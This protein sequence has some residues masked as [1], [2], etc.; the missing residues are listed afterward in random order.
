[1]SSKKTIKSPQQSNERGFQIK[2]SNENL[3]AQNETLETSSYAKISMFEKKLIIEKD[4]SPYKKKANRI[5]IIASI[6]VL[7]LIVAIIALT[8]T[9]ISLFGKK[10]K[11]KQIFY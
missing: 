11:K 1:M 2:Q 3:N 6:L 7:F 8:A 5:K 10:N 9:I 4:A